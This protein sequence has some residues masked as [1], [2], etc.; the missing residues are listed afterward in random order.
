ML[1]ATHTLLPSYTGTTLLCCL[2][3]QLLVLR[4]SEMLN[5]CMMV[6]I[7]IKCREVAMQYLQKKGAVLLAV[8][9]ARQMSG[10]DW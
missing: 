2:A 7:L 10:L 5:L 9:C 6:D 1:S 4:L 8:T 3:L